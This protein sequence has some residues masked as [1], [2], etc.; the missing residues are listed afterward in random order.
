MYFGAL[1]D[2]CLGFCVNLSARIFL[3]AM[4]APLPYTIILI[5]GSIFLAFFLPCV[6]AGWHEDVYVHAEDSYTTP[7]VGL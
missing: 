6:F 4:L 3:I 7:Q 2:I 1:H 5:S